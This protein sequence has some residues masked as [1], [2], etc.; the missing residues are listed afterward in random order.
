MFK[1]YTTMDYKHVHVNMRATKGILCYV[2]VARLQL[3]GPKW[4]QK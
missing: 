2:Y 1:T 4:F 3:H